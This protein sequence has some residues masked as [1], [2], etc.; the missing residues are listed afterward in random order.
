MRILQKT[1][2]KFRFSSVGGEIVWVVPPPS[3]SGIHEGLGWDPDPKKMF[4]VILVVTIASWE[5]GTTQDIVW[6]PGECQAMLPWWSWGALKRAEEVMDL[7]SY[8]TEKPEHK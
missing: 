3:N 7:S 8:E 5:G 4:H 1:A 6:L 2:T